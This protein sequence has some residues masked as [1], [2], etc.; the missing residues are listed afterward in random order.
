MK[1]I[2][3]SLF[4][5]FSTILLFGQQPSVSISCNSTNCFNPDPCGT[6]AS[7]H[8]TIN[9]GGFGGSN[10]TREIKW[11]PTGDYSNTSG[12]GTTDFTKGWLNTPNAQSITVTVI[13]T[14]STTGGTTNATNNKG[15]TVKYLSSITSMS[16]S[17]GV[18]ANPSNG[19]SVSVPCGSQSLTISVPTLTTNP[20]SG[21]I[22]TWSLPSGWSGSSTSNSISVNTS[23]GDGGIISQL[24]H[25]M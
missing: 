5:I 3:L 14:N 22:Y 10:Y 12:Q 6:A 17:G 16:V 13:Y 7:Y 1:N 21:V 9:D 23:T 15:V 11:V 25:H 18:T 20:S 8:A 2:F 19:G 4:F 24:A